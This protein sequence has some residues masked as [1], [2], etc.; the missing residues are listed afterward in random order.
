[1]HE[2]EQGVFTADSLTGGRARCAAA[3]LEEGLSMEHYDDDDNKGGKGKREGKALKEFDCPVC[4]ANNPRDEPIEAGQEIRCN[5][6]GNDFLT[7]FTD[8]GKLKLKEL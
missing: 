7:S 3:H 5:Y 1:V 4:N 2:T 6:C 8:S